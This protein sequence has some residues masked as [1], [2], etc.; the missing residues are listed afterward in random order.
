LNGYKFV[1]EQ[2]IGNFIVDFACRSQ[3]LIIE[4]DGGQ[5]AENVAY[6]KSRSEFLQ[7]KG[8]KV[9]RIWNDEVFTNIN[10]VLEAI[11]NLLEGESGSN[12][13]LQK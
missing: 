3:K 4:L 9:L 2:V 11:L 5:H 12:S 8:Y 1:K 10:G 7:T 6:D 13:H